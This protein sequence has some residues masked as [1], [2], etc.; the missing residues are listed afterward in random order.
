MAT[1]SGRGYTGSDHQGGQPVSRQLDSIESEIKDLHAGLNLRSTVDRARRIGELLLRAK[2]L[3]G[4]GNYLPWL[5]TLAINLRTARVYTQV[6]M[7]CPKVQS[8]APL[9][10]ADALTIIREGKFEERRQAR[11]EAVAD[12]PAR[13]LAEVHHADCRT[14]PWPAQADCIATDPPWS[15][16]AAYEWLGRW[17][18]QILR[19]GG[20]LLCQCGTSDLPK[21]LAQLTAG[22]LTYR[23]MMSIVYDDTSHSRPHGA[24]LMGWRPV[25]VL[26]QGE[27]DSRRPCCDTYTLRAPTKKKHHPWEQPLAPWRHWVTKLTQSGSLVLDP[28]AGS[29]TIGVAC[30]T[31]VRRYIGTEVDKKHARAARARIAAA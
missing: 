24:W 10:I 1:A 18:A 4:H 23:W 8:A 26:S 27:P 7:G 16:N 5:R 2:R 14:H 22:G 25:V 30:V 13:V 12:H 19:P 17:A 6:A 21:R 15:D 28:Y 29:G 31:T 11:E 9:T 20:L 3:L